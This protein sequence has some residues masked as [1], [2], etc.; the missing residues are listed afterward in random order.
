MSKKTNN[1][2]IGLVLSIQKDKDDV[3]KISLKYG[4]KILYEDIFSKENNNHLY[5]FDEDSIALTGTYI[6]S[7]VS[8]VL[9]GV[10]EYE[11][12]LRLKRLEERNKIYQKLGLKTTWKKKSGCS[13]VLS[14]NPNHLNK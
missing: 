4:I 2:P 7:R 10:K 9:H 11:D 12:Y 8:R 1:E 3:R 6:I 13:V 5:L 14:N